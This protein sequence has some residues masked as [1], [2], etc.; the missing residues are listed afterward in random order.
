M[1]QQTVLT[2]RR[3]ETKRCLGLR[4]EFN[5]H[6]ADEAIGDAARPDQGLNFECQ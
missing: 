3:E 1:S 2:G 5:T 4:T 6:S